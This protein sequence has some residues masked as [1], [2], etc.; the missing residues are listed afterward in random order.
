MTYKELIEKFFISEKPAQDISLDAIEHACAFFGHPEGSSGSIHVAGTNGKGSVSRM[1]FQMLKDRGEKVGIFTSPHLIDIRE[2]FETERGII[3]EEEFTRYAEMVL[4][5][6]ES[7]SYFERCTLIAFLFFRDQE[8][9]YS[10][11]EV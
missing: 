6:P 11:V 10:V 4:A 7:L 3:S 9:R 2:R 5:Y 1:I 8:C